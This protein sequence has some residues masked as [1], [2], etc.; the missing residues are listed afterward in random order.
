MLIK[1]LQ[2]ETGATAVEYGLIASILSLAVIVGVGLLAGA[3]GD[4]WG[5]NNGAIGNALN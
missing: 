4:L 1:F 3:I 5:D 2:D